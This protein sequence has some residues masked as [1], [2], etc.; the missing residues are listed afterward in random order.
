VNNPLL[1]IPATQAGASLS[2]ASS[3]VI[4]LHGRGQSPAFMLDLARRL[5]APGAAYL[6]L[7]AL[8]GSWYPNSFLAPLAANQPHLDRALARIEAEVQ[9]LMSQG[10]PRENIV[11]AGFSQG[12]CLACEYLRRRPGRIGGLI[13]WTGGLIDMDAATR[14]ADGVLA[15][16]PVLV[17]NGDA[18][19]WVPLERV[20]QTVDAFRRAGADVDLRVYPG[21]PH[22][23]GADELLAAGRL[24]QRLAPMTAIQATG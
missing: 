7:S 11:L 6:A 20:R 21:R 4:L 9:S 2:A 8:E 15:G 23:V 16:V 22:E 12:A 5:E 19:D 14:L 24:L 1:E 10:W 13:D 3:A 17:T 18:D